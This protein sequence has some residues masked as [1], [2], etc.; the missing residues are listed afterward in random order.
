MTSI[1]D[2]QD[3][4]LDID[5]F[6]GTLHVLRDI[7]LT[8][9]RGDK[10]GIVGESGSG[11]SVLV[12][13]ML[14]IGPSNARHVGGTMSF[15]G[16]DLTC[17]DA[18]GWRKVRGVRISMIFQDPMTYLNPL[19]AI[20][21]QI[22]D[23]IAAHRKAAG[24]DTGSKAER[25]KVAASLLT[26][27]DIPDPERVLKQYAFQLSGGMRQRVLISMA[28]AGQPDILIADEPTT[29]LD[30]TVQAQ[31]LD[32]INELAERLNLTVIF[33]SHDIG[34]V[35]TVATR[36][37]VMRQGEIVEQGD[38]LD[39]LSA[40][41]HSYTRELLDAIPEFGSSEQAAETGAA[42]EAPT[43]GPIL[44][45]KDLSKQFD[46]GGGKT[47]DAVKNVSFDVQQNEI[48]GI[49]GESGSGK[50]TIARMVLRLIEPTN[51]NI[52]FQDRDVTAFSPAEMLA[53]RKDMQMVFQNP[54][55]ALDGRHSI[56]DAIG[57]PLRLNTSIS[58][59]ER[60]KRVDELLDIV[61]LPQ[62]FKYRY[63]HELSGGQKQRV[64]I[65]RS[66]ALNPKLLVL[67]EPTSAL[68]V[69]VQA[70]VLDFLKEL[71]SE[72]NL[73]YLFISHDL[74]VV[75]ALC[76]RCIVMRKGEI[77]E[78][79]MT[80]DIFRNPNQAYTQALIESGRKTSKDAAMQAAHAG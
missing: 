29:A 48:L 65:A 7:S 73:T 36:C 37:A 21:T 1:L 10:F 38:I 44:S 39:V 57:E 34:A 77:V 13:T 16:I 24:E 8:L 33:I 32:L 74:A 60:E 58:R 23:V 56:G 55:S 28:L 64:C 27:V 46:I 12:R 66:I 26:Q 18:K 43:D 22:S 76:D 70:K 69:S 62:L 20:G 6:D 71:Q 2:V 79:G 51:G 78:N 54:H 35:A 59:Y 68:D 53:A 3:F 9:E 72:M 5:T 4:S 30:V 63:P 75:R 42:S 67:D 49:V 19:V 40:P 15:D 80:E 50:S 41:K 45:I 25:L 61:Q 14:G 47:V 52:I 17:L 31:V 11:K